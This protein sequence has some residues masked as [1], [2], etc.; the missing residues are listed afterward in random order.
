MG[1]RDEEMSSFCFLKV[2][3]MGRV[4]ARKFPHYISRICRK[5]KAQPYSSSCLKGVV[6]FEEGPE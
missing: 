2:Y 3:L 4:I 6:V 1:Y 5:R